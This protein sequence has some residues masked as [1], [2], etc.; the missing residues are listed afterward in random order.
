MS[1]ISHLYRDLDEIGMNDLWTNVWFA[2]EDSQKF[3]DKELKKFEPFYEQYMNYEPKYLYEY[4][5]LIVLYDQVPR[6]IFRNSAKAYETDRKALD[7]ARSLV[8]YMD[9]LPIQFNISI[10]M[11][12]VHSEELEDLKQAKQFIE[13][14]EI[15]YAKYNVLKNLKLIFKNHNDRMELFGRIPERNKYL[16][17]ASTEM[18]LTYLKN[19]NSQ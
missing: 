5:A 16:G 1:H 14:L 4:I 17:R 18:E 3:M 10:I 2:K 11:S 12:F 7:L 9:K 8:P 19:I 13:A 15:K 6:N